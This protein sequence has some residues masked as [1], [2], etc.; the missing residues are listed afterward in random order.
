MR[1][2]DTIICA[3]DLAFF[4]TD[5]LFALTWSGTRHPDRVLIIRLDAIGD[6]VLWL[7]AAQATVRYYKSQGKK[8]VLL[9]NAIWALWAKEL[10]IFDDVIALDR[11]SFEWNMLYR[12]S[13]ASRIRIL[14]CAIALHPTSSREWLTGDSVMR[15]SGAVERIGSS[16]DS[17]NIEPWQKRITDRWYTRLI[18]CDTVERTE[19]QRNAEFVRGLGVANFRAK[20]ADLRATTSPRLDDSFAGTTVATRRYYVLFPGAAW[21]G[22]QWPVANFAQFA[23][24]LSAKTG[25]CGVVCGGPADRALGEDLVEMCS[26]MVRNWAGNTD[27][28]QLAAILSNAQFLLTNETSAVHIAAAYGVPTVCILGGGHYG[29]FMPYQVKEANGG[30]LPHEIIHPMPCFGCNWHCIYE[31]S[32][33]RPVP[34]VE[35]IGVTEVWEATSEI[36][37]FAD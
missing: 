1:W 29:R 23:C 6:F 2:K 21:K 22:R 34:C 4:C 35:K 17:A 19:L 37:G 28:S 14:G 9:A 36:L 18:N 32:D 20:V 5:T 3:R 31:R 15:L 24:Q 27:L 8:V 26:G 10:S 7:D 16:G 33:G 11:R 25:W 13:I 12:Y 30:P